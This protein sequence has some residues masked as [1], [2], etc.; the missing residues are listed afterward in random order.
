VEGYELKALKGAEGLIDT[1]RPKMWIEI[2]KTALDKH[3]SSAR[4]IF[5]FLLDYG[6]EIASY[7]DAEGMQY[8]ILCLPK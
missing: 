1:H 3:E 6:Y 2:N 4:E 5:N 8:D 7:P